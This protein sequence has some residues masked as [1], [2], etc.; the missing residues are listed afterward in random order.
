MTTANKVTICRLLLIPIFVYEL[1][2]YLDSGLSF[3]R[4]AALI[5]FLIASVGDAVDGFV[6]RRFNQQT[7]LGAFLD[8]LADKLLLVVGLL[9]LTLHDNPSLV[10]IPIWL[11]MTAITRDILL[12]LFTVLIA[13]TVGKRQ[14]KPHIT[15]K[16]ATVFQMFSILW[17]LIG[18]PPAGLLYIASIA[19]SLTAISGVIYTLR[20]IKILL[21]LEPQEIPNTPAL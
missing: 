10:K 16:C 1:F 2:Q 18:L 12:A 13:F 9:I 21:G 19:T 7:E 11:T 17:I 4:I 20:A 8:P 14:V 5:I 3:H 6:A 15:G